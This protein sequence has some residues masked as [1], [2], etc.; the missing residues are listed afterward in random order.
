VVLL[1]PV[2]DFATRRAAW[3]ILRFPQ[4]AII[5]DGLEEIDPTTEQTVETL[6]RVVAWCVE[7]SRIDL[8]Y[9]KGQD[10]MQERNFTGLEIHHTLTLG[11][12]R[13]ESCVAGVW[14]YM[15]SRRDANIVFCFDIDEEGNRVIIVTLIRRRTS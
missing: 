5:V 7:W 14:R 8:G 13:T 6:H 4:I 2:R 15:A 10:R 3:K 9:H 12:L 1:G 11:T